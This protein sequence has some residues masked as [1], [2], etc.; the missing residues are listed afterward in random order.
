MTLH[1]ERLP[2]STEM[3]AITYGPIV[4]AGKLGEAGLSPGADIIINEREIGTMLNDPIDVPT[5]IGEPTT[6]V[7][8]IK[9]LP[10]AALTFAAPAT[11]R[12]DG[13]TLM[14]YF[15]IAHERY[16]I[17]WKFTPSA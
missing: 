14:P 15:R 3:V 11:G 8:G 13:V 6:I 2:N 16:S 17:Y 5:L 1:A 9:P 10:G 4:L 12:P 7:D